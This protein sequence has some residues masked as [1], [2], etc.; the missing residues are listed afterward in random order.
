MIVNGKSYPLWSQFVENQERWIGGILHDPGDVMT[1]PCTTKI[2]GIELVPNGKSSAFFRIK[3]E[4]FD[5]GFDVS[6]G[7]VRASEEEGLKFVSYGGD[8]FSIK[9]PGEGT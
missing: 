4:D 8:T 7:G 9:E 5:C 6:C 2:T 1:N 3:G